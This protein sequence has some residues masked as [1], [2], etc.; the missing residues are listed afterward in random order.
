MN[1]SMRDPVCGMEISRDSLPW[2]IWAY[3]TLSAPHN[4]RIGLMRI[5]LFYIGMP[6]EKA[7]KQKGM[8]DATEMRI[9]TGGQE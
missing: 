5:R 7:P 2:S 4:A 3:I 6:S 1:D 9:T 8:E